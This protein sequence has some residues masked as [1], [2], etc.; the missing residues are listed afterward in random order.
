MTPAY[1]E[2]VASYYRQKTREILR[3]YGPGPRVHFHTGLVDAATAQRASAS[4]EEEIR[5]A[6][7]AGQEALLDHVCLRSPTPIAGRVLDVG[8]GLGGGALHLAA[9]PGVTRV[10]A[11]TL[12]AS[13]VE[14]TRR[15]AVQA[16]VDGRVHARVLDAHDVTKDHGP[17]DHVLAIESSGY[18]DRLRWLRRMADVLAAPGV[19]HVVD[20]FRADGRE[21]PW[22]DAYWHTRVGTPSEYRDAFAAAG[23]GR[24]E[25]EDLGTRAMPF[26]TLS[27]AWIEKHEREEVR[28]RKRAAHEQLLG[29]LSTGTL[30][31]LRWT[32]RR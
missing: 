12:E 16:G 9:Q 25:V 29:A 20:C 22:F 17:Y 14:L 26:W 5:R 15:F 2:D 24:V 8:C 23:L 1:R 10:D 31:Y 18:L 6:M 7:T 27:L 28:D 30:R 13:H 32:A 3:K 11:I 21:L 19:L 4:T